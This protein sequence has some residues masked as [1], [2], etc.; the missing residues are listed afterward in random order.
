MKNKLLLIL[1]SLSLLII[2]ACGPSHTDGETVASD[3]M[4][5]L[6]YNGLVFNPSESKIPF[7]NDIKWSAPDT[8]H[9]K[10]V[11]FEITADMTQAEMGLYT[12]LNTLAVSGFSPASPIGIPLNNAVELTNLTDKISII[13]LT[14]LLTL[15]QIPCA[16][17]PSPTT[18]MGTNYLSNYVAVNETARLKIT[19]DGKTIKMYP[20]TPLDAGHQYLVVIDGGIIDAQ[21]ANLAAPRLFEFLKSTETLTGSLAA[22]EPIRVAYSAI[23]PVL[24]LIGT[25]KEDVLEI[26]TFTTADKVLS[27]ADLGLIQAGNPQDV[28]GI[29][30]ANLDTEINGILT[31]TY[32]AFIPSGGGGFAEVAPTAVDNINKT[33]NSFTFTSLASLPTPPTVETVPFTLIQAPDNSAT[34]VVI[35]QHGYTGNSTNV[36]GMAY[37]QSVSAT[38]GKNVSLIAMDLPFHGGRVDYD[39]SSFDCDANGTVTSGECYLTSN[40]PGTRVNFLQSVFDQKMLLNYLSKGLIDING[41]GTAD[42][43]DIPTNIYF[44]GMSMGSITGSIF[45]ANEDP[46]GLGAGFGALGFKEVTKTVLNVGGG[47]LATLFDT[48]QDLADFVTKI[49]ADKEIEKDSAGYFGFL[50]TLQWL[51]DDADPIYQAQKTDITTKLLL[52]N[53]YKDTFVT[54]IT[55]D[56]LS[57]A[58]G[59]VANATV[60]N[61]ETDITSAATGLYMFK[62]LDES[63]TSHSFLLQLTSPIEDSNPLALQAQKQIGLFIATP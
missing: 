61:E 4:S 36:A 34:D 48:S 45:V 30:Y 31:G 40:I 16:G 21:G 27:M 57:N 3:D 58:M 59:V 23:W 44:V 60:I 47:G 53:A 50:G 54:N 11:Y 17:D 10:K 51:I 26:F 38:L 6:E 7:P 49:L 14:D 56:I 55:N 24:P 12:A 43:G 63:A 28:N 9:D 13:D 35:F 29:D 41:D 37:A 42:A 22:L 62:L 19:Q 46:A 5:N 15:V 39:N 25:T 2:T 20:I 8:D 18:C 32:G 52:Q 33:F 1:I